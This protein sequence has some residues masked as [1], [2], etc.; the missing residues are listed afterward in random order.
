MTLGAEWSVDLE[1][2]IVVHAQGWVFEIHSDPRGQDCYACTLL[3]VPKPDAAQ[4]PDVIA[5]GLFA[6]AVLA[7]RHALRRRH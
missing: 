6:Q 4:A 5:G 7:Y 3:A 2:A 1:Q